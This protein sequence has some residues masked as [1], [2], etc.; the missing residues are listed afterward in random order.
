MKELIYD[1]GRRIDLP[2]TKKRHFENLW[3]TSKDGE[4]VTPK[5]EG[6]SRT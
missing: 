3:G 4:Q 5:V 6:D 2:P 1:Y